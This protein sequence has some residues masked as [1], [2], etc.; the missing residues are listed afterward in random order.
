ML[1]QELDTFKEEMG[2]RFE[3][4]DKGMEGQRYCRHARVRVVD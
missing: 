3:A 2:N 4:I 1:G